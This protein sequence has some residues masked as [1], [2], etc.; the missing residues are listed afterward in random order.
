L[1]KLGK[2]KTLGLNPRALS[3]FPL[4]Y[5]I[6]RTFSSS[7]WAG[8][9][10]VAHLVAWCQ[11]PSVAPRE[12]GYDNTPTYSVYYPLLLHTQQKRRNLTTLPRC[13]WLECQRH[14][15]NDRVLIRIGDRQATALT[16]AT[17]VH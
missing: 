14:I 2:K 4:L 13:T 7:H 6:S 16:T 8:L 12:S 9:V 10:D 15:L 11:N 3:F 1:F 17:V 5:S